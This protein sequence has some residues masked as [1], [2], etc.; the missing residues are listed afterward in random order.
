MF[1]AKCEQ[2]PCECKKKNTS[3]Q[4]RCC[5]RD[6][7]WSCGKPADTSMPVTSSENRYYCNEHYEIVRPLGEMDI[8]LS[9]HKT[10][11]EASYGPFDEHRGKDTADHCL[12]IMRSLG[13]QGEAL[14]SY[15][16]KSRQLK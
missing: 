3:N 11:L 4:Y 9:H 12:K 7:N 6:Q 15:L 1:C 14:A 13:A 10:G 8:M 5:W 16:S 2:F